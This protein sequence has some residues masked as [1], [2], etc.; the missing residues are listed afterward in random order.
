[1]FFDHNFEMYE[2]M[3]VIIEEINFLIISSLARS[4]HIPSPERNKELKFFDLNFVNGRVTALNDDGVY[5]RNITRRLNLVISIGMK[6]NNSQKEYLK[7][8]YIAEYGWDNVK[9]RELEECTYILFEPSKKFNDYT[10]DLKI[11]MFGGTNH[12]EPAIFKAYRRPRLKKLAIYNDYRLQ[13]CDEPAIL[14]CSS[15]GVPDIWCFKEDYDFIES[16]YSSKDK[17]LEEKATHAFN[18]LFYKPNY[19]FKDYPDKLTKIWGF[20]ATQVGDEGV[21]VEHFD[22]NSEKDALALDSITTCDKINISKWAFHLHTPEYYEYP[23]VMKIAMSIADSVRDDLIA[24]LKNSLDTTIDQYK[25][26]MKEEVKKPT[27]D[28]EE[29][30]HPTF[31]IMYCNMV[32]M[33]EDDDKTETGH[34]LGPV[35]EIHPTVDTHSEFL[36][37]PE[38]FFPYSFDNGIHGINFY[39]TEPATVDCFA[40]ANEEWEMIAKKKYDEYLFNKKIKEAK[41]NDTNGKSVHGV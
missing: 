27:D 39:W 11:R 13:M 7:S 2:S 40:F 24:E 12:A 10:K 41:E 36:N 3:K 32:R 23:A 6:F 8:Y 16:A 17:E 37:K 20:R 15:D 5:G 33:Y 18:R 30:D 21:K 4:L 34:P 14:H 26:K 25:Q 28:D 35:I 29:E 1:M 22:F 31:K 19:Y 38:S 9:F